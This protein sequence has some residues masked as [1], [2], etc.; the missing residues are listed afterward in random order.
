VQAVV[1]A[2]WWIAGAP[3]SF[4]S[5]MPL[6]RALIHEAYLPVLFLALG[7]I[8]LA[9]ANVLRP[10]WAPLQLGARAVLDG[11]SAGVAFVFLGASWAQV[12]AD[13]GGEAHKSV[14]SPAWIDALVGLSGAVALG[15]A[16]AFAAVASGVY[17]TRCASGHI[18][19]QRTVAEP[20]RAL[21]GPQE[22]DRTHSA[23]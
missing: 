7:T 8:G 10:Y 5:A 15:A 4:I 11:L 16:G 17:A 23:S 1:Y 6:W 22:V 3:F 2:F 14:G 21:A 13:A 18:A 20:H 9:G 12:S 19:K